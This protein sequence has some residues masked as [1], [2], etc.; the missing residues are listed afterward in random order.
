[1]LVKLFGRAD[2]EEADI[3]RTSAARVRDI[4]IAQALYARLFLVALTLTAALATA[5]A[6]GFG[7]VAAVHGELAVGTVVALTAYLTRLYQ[8]LTQLSNLNLDVVTTLVSFERIFE[9]LDL[10]PML[11]PG[12]GRACP[13][14]RPRSSSTTS[15]SRIRTPTRSRWPRSRRSPCSRRA[16]TTRSSTTSRSASSLARW[17]RWSARRAPA[18]RPSRRSWPASTT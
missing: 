6:Y 17:W 3:S 5:F 2:E 7:G 9:V 18:R 8:P 4:G 11:Q 12:P 15:I 1:M 13:P 16:S 10:V 14:A